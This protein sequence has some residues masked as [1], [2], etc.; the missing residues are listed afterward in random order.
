MRDLVIQIVRRG[1]GRF[2]AAV[3]GAAE[4]LAP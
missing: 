2:E 4:G 1:E 3:R